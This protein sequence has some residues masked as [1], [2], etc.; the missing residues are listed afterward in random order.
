VALRVGFGVLDPWNTTHKISAQL[1]GL[2][3]Q[4][5]RPR[6]AHDPVLRE[7]YHLQFDGALEFL[8]GLDEGL[9]PY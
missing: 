5:C 3:H 9:D 7:R 8:P 2:A 4:L 1:H 6:L